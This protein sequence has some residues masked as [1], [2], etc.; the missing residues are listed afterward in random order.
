[1]KRSWLTKAIFKEETGTKGKMAQK[2]FN[3]KAQG[4]LGFLQK[5][6]KGTKRKMGTRSF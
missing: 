4:I 3:A 2:V 6:T 1:M 5:E